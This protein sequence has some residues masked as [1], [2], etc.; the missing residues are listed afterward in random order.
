MSN[1]NDFVVEKNILKRYTGKDPYVE[2]PDGVKSI[3]S[4]AFQRNANIRAVRLPDSVTKINDKAFSGCISL[5]EINIPEKVKTIGSEAFRNC[6]HLQNIVFFGE[7]EKIGLLAFWG[8]WKLVKNTPPLLQ[9]FFANMKE[10][11]MTLEEGKNLY[12][13]SK[14][15]GTATIKEFNGVSMQAWDGTKYP[16]V[17]SNRENTLIIPVLIGDLPVAKAPSKQIPEDAI[18]YCGA[19]HFDKLPRSNKAILAVQWLMEDKMLREELTEKILA[20]IKKYADDVVYALSSCEDPAVY[21]RFLE[22][23]KPKAALIEKMVEQCSGKTEI[24]AVLLNSGKSAKREAVNLTLDAKPKMS[25]AELKK[26]WTYQTYTIAETGEKA[27]EITNYK[28]HEKR[29]EIPEYIGKARVA[30]V[31]GVFPSEVESVDF[32][33]EEME[34]KCS[35]RNCKAMADANGFIY[36]NAGSRCVLT[37]YIGSNDI[38][39]LIVPDGITETAYGVLRELNAREVILPDGFVSLAGSSFADCCRLQ[40]VTLPESLR[41]IEQMAFQDCRA[42]NQL[43]IPEG[44]TKIGIL[45]LKRTKDASFTIYG[46]QGSAAHAYAEKYGHTFVEGYPENILMPDFLIKDGILTGYVGS[47]GDIV[48]PEDVTEIGSFVF[49]KNRKIT[50]LMIGNQVCVIH[51]YAFANC[52]NLA[53]VKISGNVKVIEDC[54]FQIS[55]LKQV[56]LEEG[57]EE[58]GADAFGYLSAT[59]ATVHI[60]SSVREIGVDAFYSNM[61]TTTLYVKVGSYAE[62]YAKENNI[63]FVAE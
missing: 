41:T 22:T 56:E 27:V 63:P 20:F 42:L 21:Q 52:N 17:F 6:R 25:V 46:K 14:A 23:A 58:I 18:V 8:C 45:D 19:E 54:A 15:K 61:G 7:P 12:V 16:Y 49:N 32:P 33:N 35:F 37:D 40:K 55:G 24:L 50:S 34:I 11:K 3:D 57:V 5:E 4:Y 13:F 2:V 29:V 1:L 44:V 38:E 43:Y 62:T 47:G 39:K 31:R 51:S 48:I 53:S 30:V 10:G 9:E 28:G 59:G 36:V 26:L 60:P